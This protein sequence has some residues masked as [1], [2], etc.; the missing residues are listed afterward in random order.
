VDGYRTR[1]VDG[2]LGELLPGLP[3]ISLEGPKD[4]ALRFPGIRD[5]PDRARR[6]QLDGCLT[7]IVERDFPGQGHLVRRPATLRAWLAA[8]ASATASTASYNVIPAALLGP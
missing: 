4:R 5:L 1:V 7:R 2:E 3:A 8:Y 6:A